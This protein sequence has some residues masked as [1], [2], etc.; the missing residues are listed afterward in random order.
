[1]DREPGQIWLRQIYLLPENQRK[2]VGAFLVKQLL[3][4]GSRAN[5]PIRLRVI[6]LNP[7]L[8]FYGR[9]DFV[10]TETTPDL[11]Y[12]QHAA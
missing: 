1:V 4:E 8:S 2:G 11:V 7:A 12:L 9:L 10:V 3:A 6:A 5:V